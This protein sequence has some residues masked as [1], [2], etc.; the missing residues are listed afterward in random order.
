MSLMSFL[1]LVIDV[2]CYCNVGLSDGIFD[3][4]EGRLCLSTLICM[5]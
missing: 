4:K 5:W 3:L 2:L 1:L